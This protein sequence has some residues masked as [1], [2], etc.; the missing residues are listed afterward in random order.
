MQ[1]KGI[2]RGL[3][4][5]DGGVL[6]VHKIFQ[7]STSGSTSLSCRLQTTQIITKT[8]SNW[9]LPKRAGSWLRITTAMALGILWRDRNQLIKQARKQARKP[10]KMPW[11]YNCCVPGC[12][13]SHNCRGAAFLLGIFACLVSPNDPKCLCVDHSDPGS[14]SFW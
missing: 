8:K 13:N 5:L 1:Y 3:F 6:P 14:H 4:Y 2:E 12:T 7:I 9:P 10:A 11:Q